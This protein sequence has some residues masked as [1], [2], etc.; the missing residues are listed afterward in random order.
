MSRLA[1]DAPDCVI[2]IISFDSLMPLQT[3]LVVT[4]TILVHAV[5]DT[6]GSPNTNLTIQIIL[7]QIECWKQEHQQRQT[8]T[9]S[10]LPF[11]TLTFAQTLDGRIALRSLLNEDDDVVSSSSNLP[12]SG[13][14]SW[15]MSHALRSIHDAILIGGRTFSIDNPRLTNRLWPPFFQQPRPVILDTHLNHFRNIFG[16]G[17]FD[18]TRCRCH[19]PIFCCSPE[20][21][22]NYDHKLEVNDFEILPCKTDEHG[23]L[24]LHKLL[25]ILYEKYGIQ[26]LMVEGGSAVLTSFALSNLVDCI[27]VSITPNLVG[28]ERGLPSFTSIATTTTTDKYSFPSSSNGLLAL[29]CNSRFFELGVDC[30]FLSRWPK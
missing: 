19:R 23:K 25:S 30:S 1:M 22:V 2:D 5:G 20:A 18:L 7:N 3:I 26:S 13:G 24:D 11:V 15:R 8:T 29:N 6:L 27:C 28:D 14:D 21:A 17:T 4:A 16:N 9:T 10:R 12:L